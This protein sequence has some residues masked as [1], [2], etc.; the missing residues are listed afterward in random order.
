MQNHSSSFTSSSAQPLSSLSEYLFGPH[1]EY[2]SGPLLTV[3]PA[4]CEVE[5]GKATYC[6]GLH[7][8]VPVEPGSRA[9]GQDYINRL[10]EEEVDLFQN[11]LS[12]LYAFPVRV[13]S[14]GAHLT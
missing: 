10:L 6:L 1:S 9:E 7:Y 2:H 8:T 13:Y 4:E 5:D 12:L 14:L 11:T 3:K